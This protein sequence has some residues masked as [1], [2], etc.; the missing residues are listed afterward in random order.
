MLMTDEDMEKLRAA[1][2]S[3]GLNPEKVTWTGAT[4]LEEGVQRKEPA[5]Q[6]KLRLVKGNNYCSPRQ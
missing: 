3:T 1:A 4:R 5:G 6:E 2:V